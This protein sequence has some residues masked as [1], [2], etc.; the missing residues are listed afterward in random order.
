MIVLPREDGAIVLSG[1]LRELARL[2]T[3][4]NARDATLRIR[5][6]LI[7]EGDAASKLVLIAA[8]AIEG[9]IAEEQ[10]A[11][12]AQVRGGNVVSL[13]QRKPA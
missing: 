11:A 4:A 1:A 9:I 6:I 8:A 10:E 7:A 13:A 2:P 12:L 5:T 3:V